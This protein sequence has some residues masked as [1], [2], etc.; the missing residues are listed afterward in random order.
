MINTCH[1]H[2][3]WGQRSQDIEPL[4]F[5]NGLLYI[6]LSSLILENKILGNNNTPFV[7]DHPY[8]SVDIDVEE[9]F[10]FAEYII[11]NYPDE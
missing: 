1:T 2:I 4:Y 6:I 8:A 7:V 9:D 5:E 3:K 11:K 10:N